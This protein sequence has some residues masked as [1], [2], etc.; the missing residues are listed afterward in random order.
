M[1]N[2]KAS[3]LIVLLMISMG[4]ACT[5]LDETLY[6]QVPVD[7]FGKSEEQINA[8]VGSIYSSLKLHCIDWDTYLTMDGLSSDMIAIPGFKGGDWSEPMYK[9][10]M[11]HKWNASSSGFNASYFE[12]SASI[13]LCNQIYYQIDINKAIVPELKDQILAEIRGVRAFWY[14]ILCDHY[15]NVPIVTDFLDKSQ[16]ET[17]TRQEVF[18]FIVNE[19]NDIKDKLRNDVATPASYGKMT[20]GAAYTLLAKMYLNAAV[21]NPAGGNKWEDCVKA[22]DTVLAMPY[23]LEKWDINFVSNNNISR[24]AIFSAV[25]RAGG[26][27]RQNNIALNTLHY[28]DPIALGLNI[29]PWNGI[30]A[31]PPY[32]KEFDPAD[33]RFAASFLIGPMKNPAGEIIMTPHGRPLIHTIDMVLNEVGPDG[34]GWIN[35]EEGARIKK[36]QFEPGLSTSMENDFHIF[37]LADVYLMKAEALLRSGGSNGEATSLVNTI[38]ARA[39]ADPSKLYTA[40]TLEDIYKE[41]RFELAW[42]GFTRQ[43][44]IRYNKFLLPRPPFKPNTSDPK[45]LLYAI[46]QAAIDANNK[47]KQ[48]PGY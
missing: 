15:G 2:F 11:Q 26:S 17:K 23:Q 34:W 48:N 14:Y 18:T 46:P 21:W 32:V 33:T 27:G 6:T 7:D 42:E 19:L 24:E 43:D 36:W 44:M 47:L 22:C 16:P 35:Q 37:R 41:R 38:R 9:E 31:N 28:F 10:T 12:P 30:A 1:K 29:A 4:P 39:F 45:Y 13:S 40:V 20:R 5:R 3:I 8:L 25:F